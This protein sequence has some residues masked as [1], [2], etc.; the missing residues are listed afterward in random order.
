MVSKTEVTDNKK[1]L[2]DMHVHSQSSHDSTARAVDI[3][4]EGIKK[5][6]SV[7]AIT[8][9][10]D[11]EY[12]DTIDIMSMLNSS[13]AESVQ[14]KKLYE[15]R[16]EIL[17]GVEI[18]EAIWNKA[19]ATKVKSAFNYDVIIGSVHAA[20]YE[21]YTEPYSTIDF[22]KMTS[23][24]LDRY[25]EVYFDDLLEMT[26]KSDCDIVAH[27]T[28]PLRYINGKYA[29]NADVTKNRDKILKI[30]DSVIEKSLCLEVNTSGL[31]ASYGGLMPESWIL[32]EY[33][34]RGGYLISLGSDAHAPE[35]VANRFEQAI[36]HL[37]SLGFDGYY[38]YK[39]RKPYKIDI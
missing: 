34:S 17:S 20:R 12:C 1:I 30:L 15:G 10:C 36:E 21:G 23:R 33:K 11:I 31:G 14:A 28:C 4:D 29:L 13:Y 35:R 38:Y 22:T 25:L 26:E 39:G 19:Y 3:A 5:G 16:I 6:I 8:D 27:L 9:H 32:K 37:S 18:G 24:E 7:I 2:C